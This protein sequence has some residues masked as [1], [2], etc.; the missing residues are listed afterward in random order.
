MGERP[1]VCRWVG[2]SKLFKLTDGLVVDPA[3][4]V[5]NEAGIEDTASRQCS[6]GLSS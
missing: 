6:L 2:E 3:L 1:H 4:T 5:D